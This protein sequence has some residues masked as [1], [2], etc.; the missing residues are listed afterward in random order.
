MLFL[1]NLVLDQLIIPKLIHFFI[2][3]TY[4]VEIVKR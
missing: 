1:E 4:L 3:T 2:L